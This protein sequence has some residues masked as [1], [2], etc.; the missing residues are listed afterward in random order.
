MIAVYKVAV[1]SSLVK[2]GLGNSIRQVCFIAAEAKENYRV[3]E[4]AILNRPRQELLN[5]V[6]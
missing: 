4:L 6:M 1:F 3:R 2:I 5:F